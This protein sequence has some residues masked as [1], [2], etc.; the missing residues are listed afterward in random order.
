MR[1]KPGLSSNFQP[2][3][4]QLSYHAF[5]YSLNKHQ[6][7]WGKPLVAFRRKIITIA[8]PYKVNKNSYLKK[9]SRVSKAGTEEVYFN[10]MFE[11]E[12]GKED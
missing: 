11:L 7:K 9:G 6:S 8:R 5:R 10:N 2:R 1:F 12:L 3:Y 4:V